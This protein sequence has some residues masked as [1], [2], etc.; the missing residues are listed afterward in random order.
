MSACQAGQQLIDYAQA[1][2]GSFIKTAGNIYNK[3][4][5]LYGKSGD[6]YQEFKPKAKKYL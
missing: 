4:Q 2:L 1:G 6:A 3:A 5:E